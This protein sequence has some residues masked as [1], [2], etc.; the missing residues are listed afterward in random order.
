VLRPATPLLPL[1]L[2]ANLH[3]CSRYRP[4][5]V[6]APKMRNPCGWHRKWKKPLRLWA[7]SGVA[8]AK[9]EM[10]PAADCTID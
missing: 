7:G 2:W 5:R 6:A 3:F 10:V 9:R 4:K 8:A 1:R